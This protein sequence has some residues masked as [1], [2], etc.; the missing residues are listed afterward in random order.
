MFCIICSF[1][2]FTS[3]KQ[4]MFKKVRIYTFLKLNIKKPNII[5]V[6]RNSMYGIFNSFK[7]NKDI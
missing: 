3:Q 5:I 2:E 4:I 6:R 7:M 1:H